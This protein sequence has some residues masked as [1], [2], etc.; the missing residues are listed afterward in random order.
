MTAREIDKKREHFL[1]LPRLFL[2][3]PPVTCVGPVIV[4]LL[5]PP[6]ATELS[7]EDDNK[8]ASKCLIQ[9]RMVTGLRSSGTVIIII[10]GITRQLDSC[11]DRSPF[12]RPRRRRR[13]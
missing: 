4:P 11:L 13:R 1:S 7:H 6:H 5:F 2:P 3:Q 12:R 10:I 8:V 9:E